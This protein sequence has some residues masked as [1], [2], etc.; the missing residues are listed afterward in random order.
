MNENESFRKNDLTLIG[1]TLHRNNTINVSGTKISPHKVHGDQ[2]H[3]ASQQ[4]IYLEQICTNLSI[5]RKNCFTSQ[6][7]HMERDEQRESNVRLVLVHRQMSPEMT[8]SV[9]PVSLLYLFVHCPDDSGTI[10][11][12]IESV[13][14]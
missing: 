7:Y 8:D 1:D 13:G 9:V 6:K 3:G 5:W 2:P 12:H 10:Y 11:Y 4:H 14:K